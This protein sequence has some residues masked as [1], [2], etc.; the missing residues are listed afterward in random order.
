MV[1]NS[2]SVDGV[3]TRWAA[4]GRTGVMVPEGLTVPRTRR[5]A[6]KTPPL[7]TALYASR[8]CWAVT[9]SSCPI[10]VE[11][12]EV[13]VQELAPGTRPCDSPGNPSP[14]GRPKPRLLIWAR[15]GSSPS[16]WAI[17]MV[18]MLEDWARI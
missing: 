17:S 9:A 5:G 10:G 16:L 6:M 4:D 13:P 7:A 14:V 2:A 12:I 3:I 11:P 18:P 1:V 15:R 8:I